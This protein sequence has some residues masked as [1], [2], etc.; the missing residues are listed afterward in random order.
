MPE[1][2]TRS[3]ARVVV[4]EQ[5]CTWQ[6][7][8]NDRLTFGR[9]R[10]IDITFSSDPQLSRLAG[11]LRC[12]DDGVLIVNLS[13]NHALYVRSPDGETRLPPAGE[14]GPGGGAFVSDGTVDVIAPWWRASERRL[15]VDV[16]RDG[17]RL[18]VGQRDEER[19]TSTRIPL[20]LNPDTKE[21]I[22][23]L[24]LCRPGLLG[25]GPAASPPPV[26]ELA[27]EILKTT[28]SHHLLRQFDSDEVVRARLTGRVHEHLKQLR[29]KLTNR[30]LAPPGARLSAAVIADLLIDHDIVV[31][32]HLALLD[33]PAWLERQEQ[34]WW[35]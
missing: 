2:K 16:N 5:D 19:S 7:H 35:T 31:H 21:F 3:Y 1:E 20:T 30:G 13:H 12:V 11:E 9:D 33:D 24:L 8:P 34:R 22:T 26:P 25:G 23:A 14:E 18:P 27:R 4:P 10:T 15:V 28:N 29:A 32:R 6:L 17:S